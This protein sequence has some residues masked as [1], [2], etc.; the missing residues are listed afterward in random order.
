MKDHRENKVWELK[1]SGFSLGALLRVWLIIGA[2]SFGGGAM[3]QYLIQ[4]HFIY[5]RSWI[6]EE[7]YAHF[8]AMC[9][10]APG[11]NLLAVTI[12][13]GNHLAGRMGVAIS[14]LG[15]VLPSAVITIAISAA[16][17]SISQYPRVQSALR[18]VFAAIF[19]ISLA[20]NWRMVRPILLANYKHGW[21]R[22]AFTLGLFT[23]SAVFYMVC[24]PPVA[25][26][27]ILGGLFGAAVYWRTAKKSDEGE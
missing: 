12:L 5:R 27:Y 20:T 15:L 18:T 25:I 21:Q 7:E 23:G 1:Q 3:T 26:L 17:S 2:T 4:D 19:G 14:L 13:I 6:T 8:W 16:Y 9:Q 24:K 22:F 11:I 10:I